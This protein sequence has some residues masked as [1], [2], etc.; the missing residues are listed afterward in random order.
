MLAGCCLH[1][2]CGPYPA[3]LGASD[4]IPE[5]K[6]RITIAV[7]EGSL[8]WIRAQVHDAGGGNYQT[9]INQAL[10]GHVQLQDEPLEDLVRRVF[11]EELQT[12]I[13]S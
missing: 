10:R 2:A 11:R 12:R 3:Y 13:L 4:P 7:V 6:T 8:A 5:G 9:L 1:L